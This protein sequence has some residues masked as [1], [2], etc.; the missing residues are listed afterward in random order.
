MFKLSFIKHNIYLYLFLSQILSN[1][2][3]K[4]VAGILWKMNFLKIQSIFDIPRSLAKVFQDCFGRFFENPET[5]KSMLPMGATLEIQQRE[6]IDRIEQ[7]MMA[8]AM[9]NSRIQPMVNV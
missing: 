6:R 3:F 2:P 1:F 8:A 9:Q 5:R 4:Q 7:Q